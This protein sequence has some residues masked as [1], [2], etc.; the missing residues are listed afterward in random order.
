MTPL[1][2]TGKPHVFR[3]SVRS[4]Q[5]DPFSR[6]RARL[7]TNGERSFGLLR[8]SNISW[9]WRNFGSRNISSGT[10]KLLI[11]SEAARLPKFR[12]N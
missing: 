8:K 9:D 6:T 1:A 10:E 3:C 5:T 11:L 4:P 12:S 7:A 2:N